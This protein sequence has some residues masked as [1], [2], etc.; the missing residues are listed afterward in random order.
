MNKLLLTMI[1]LIGIGYSNGRYIGASLSVDE[2]YGINIYT[3]TKNHGVMYSIN[4]NKS[5]IS[6]HSN[7]K[8]TTKQQMINNGHT[9]LGTEEVYSSFG[10][11]YFVNSNSLMLGIGVDYNLYTE[12]GA[13]MGYKK[14]YLVNKDERKFGYHLF[15]GYTAIEGVQPFII[16]KQFT[17]DFMVGIS[18]TMS[19]D[20]YNK[21]K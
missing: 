7:V 11:G 19:D 12:Y 9:Y 3:V 15:L 6:D 13:F 1:L 21:L 20:I 16:Y 17:N 8:N 14:A 10:V 5:I 18:I 4:I 2:M